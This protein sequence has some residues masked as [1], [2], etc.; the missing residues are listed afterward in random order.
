MENDTNR[1]LEV[2]K[3]QTLM[4]LWR[5][6]KQQDSEAMDQMINSANKTEASLRNL[7]FALATF[8]FTFTTPI[9]TRNIP[10][11]SNVKLL[12]FLA[13]SFLLLSILAG[14]LHMTQVIRFF[15]HQARFH[16]K[17]I[18]IFSRIGTLEE[19]QKAVEKANALNEEDIP[20]S[21]SL[22]L[23]IQSVFLFIGFVLIFSAATLVLFK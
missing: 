7:Q 2:L 9:F 20:S 4:A 5:N 12:I 3:V 8:L 6:A 19:Y 16:V 22:S 1:I 17:K 21:S 11:D 18:K 23:I 13:W 14:F 15:M 10:S